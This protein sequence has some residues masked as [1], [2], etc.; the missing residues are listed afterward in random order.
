MDPEAAE[1]EAAETERL[2]LVAL[3]RGRYAE[4]VKAVEEREAIETREPTTVQ[5][6]MFDITWGEVRAMMCK[7]RILAGSGCCGSCCYGTGKCHCSLGCSECKGTTVCP[8]C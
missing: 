5:Y 7:A 1:I 2:R 8:G 6:T 4:H 3:A